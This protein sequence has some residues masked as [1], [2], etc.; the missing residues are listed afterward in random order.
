M[1]G[2]GE[3]L[4]N[5]WAI[6][7]EDAR[8][9]R[10][11]THERQTEASLRRDEE[12]RRS[13]WVLGLWLQREA[14]GHDHEKGCEREG[15]DVEHADECREE[16][17]VLH[18]QQAT[19]QDLKRVDADAGDKV[20]GEDDGA[21]LRKAPCQ[22][23]HF[24]IEHTTNLTLCAPPHNTPREDNGTLICTRI[25]DRGYAF[26]P[27]CRYLLVRYTSTMLDLEIT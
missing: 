8:A 26:R 18:E 6:A 16:A 3:S 12:R 25:P 2:K 13:P 22:E 17:V 7:K 27:G 20:T 24:R 15:R 21:R 1:T 4:P 9:A 10:K 23:R 11:T 5:A 14:P 19:H